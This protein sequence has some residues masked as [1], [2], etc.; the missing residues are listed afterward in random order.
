MP[1]C[2]PC[3]FPAE[4]RARGNRAW[5]RARR[6]ARAHAVVARR[7]FAPSTHEPFSSNDDATD[8]TASD[9]IERVV[10]LDRGR[11]TASG[12]GARSSS[13]VSRVRSG[14]RRRRASSGV[15]A[16]TSRR[17]NGRGRPTKGWTTPRSKTSAEAGAWTKR[18]SRRTRGE[19]RAD[20][21]RGLHAFDAHTHG[22]GRP[23]DG[24]RF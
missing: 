13:C 23:R 21:S 1:S 7:L 22:N 15:P 14:S 8:D 16:P 18:C 9:S 4:R 19:S 20:A 5:L 12:A 11:R 6:R 17:A 10:P 24:E 3:S 2:S